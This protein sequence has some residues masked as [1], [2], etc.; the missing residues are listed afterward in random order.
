MKSIDY[1]LYQV[2]SSYMYEFT[3]NLDHNITSS[4]ANWILNLSS[5]VENV[6]QTIYAM[7]KGENI[8]KFYIASL[9]SSSF[10]DFISIL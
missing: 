7:K 10:E 5:V 4:V 3:W 8:V 2:C 6:A 1:I 9:I